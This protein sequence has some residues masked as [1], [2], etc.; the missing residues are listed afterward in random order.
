MS[1]CLKIGS[2]LLDSDQMI[3]A[4]VQYK[5][6]EPLV[7]HLLLDEVFKE[8]PLL[9]QEVFHTLTGGTDE[10]I[11][12]NFEQFVAHWCQQRDITLEYFQTVMVREWQLQKFKQ[13]QFAT[14]VESE[15]LRMKP[16]LDQVEYSLIQVED[17]SLAQELYFQLRDDGIAFSE[18]A[19]EH[20]LG[21]ERQSEGWVG[22]VALSSLPIDIAKLFRHQR[23]GMVYPPVPING[24][25]WI[26]QLERLIA[27]RLT[28][29]TRTQVVERLY[30]R[31]LQTQIQKVMNTPGAIA[32]QA[33]QSLAIASC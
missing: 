10:T 9:K 33:E 24:R 16:D 13:L 14:Q 31:W 4:L 19:R 11:P 25:F 23:T 2:R 8:V 15:F 26:V 22:P 1:S 7:G 30:H 20:S 6:L 28:D 29:A 21:N 5:L 18:L 17:F 27:A 32:V 3:S 12:D